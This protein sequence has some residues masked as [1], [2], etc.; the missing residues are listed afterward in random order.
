MLV[1]LRHY[2]RGL[3]PLLLK[4]NSQFPIITHSFQEILINSTC[5]SINPGFWATH[6]EKSYQTQEEDVDPW[7]L[8]LPSASRE[9]EVDS[10]NIQYVEPR[11]LE[12]L[13]R[14][15]GPMETIEVAMKHLDHYR[16]YSPATSASKSYSVKV[17]RDI[18]LLPVRRVTKTLQAEEESKYP[19]AF[20]PGPLSVKRSESTGGAAIMV[21]LIDPETT[22]LELRANQHLDKGI[23]DGHARPRDRTSNFLS[24]CEGN[25][26]DMTENAYYNIGRMISKQ[27]QLVYGYSKHTLGSHSL[28]ISSLPTMHT[29]L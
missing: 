17:N 7:L 5:C 27:W 21:I 16:N 4:A 6:F 12:Y 23:S 22:Q 3:E 25:Q 1:Y 18:Q 20:I 19:V 24:K 15:F 10:F 9:R 11:E 26:E 8:P 28:P 29:H 14:P 2:L 13:P